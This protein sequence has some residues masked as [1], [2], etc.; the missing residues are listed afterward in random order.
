MMHAKNHV[1]KTAREWVNKMNWTSVEVYTQACLECGEIRIDW[2][3]K[4]GGKC[5]RWTQKA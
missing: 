3:R 1:L 4:C 2:G 5:A